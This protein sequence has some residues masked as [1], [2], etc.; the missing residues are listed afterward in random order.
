MMNLMISMKIEIGHRHLKFLIGVIGRFKMRHGPFHK[1][2]NTYRMFIYTNR[3]DS[4]FLL[5]LS[6]TD[7]SIIK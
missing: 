5:T 2:P 1:L 3:Y 4:L 6:D 7:M